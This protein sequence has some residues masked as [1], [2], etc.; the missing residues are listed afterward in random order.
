[1][2]IYTDIRKDILN[3]A[4]DS[5]HGHIPTCFS[6]VELIQ[7]VYETMKNDPTN[8]EWDE[9]DIFILSKG[10]AALVHYVVL[11]RRGYFEM[12]P[13]CGFGGCESTF[14]CHGDR[15]KTPGVEVSTGSLGHGIGVAVGIAMAFKIQKSDRKVYVIVGDGESNEGSV[16]EALMVA[17]DQNLTNLTVIYDNNNSHARGLQ[18]TNPGEKLS[19]FGMNVIEIDGHDT[20]AIKNALLADTDKPKAILA[21]TI[22]GKGISEMSDN[23]YPWH[24][25]SPSKEELDRFMEELDA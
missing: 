1:M 8:P 12:E 10:H 23:H 21:N 17:A 24:R 7:T 18:I 20:A 19:A 5:G 25:R 14:G 22:K 9:R 3:I 6:I 11:A 2:S 16:W 13:V 4:F 15:N